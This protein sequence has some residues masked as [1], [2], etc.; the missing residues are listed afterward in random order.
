MGVIES[1]LSGD[2][3]NWAWLWKIVFTIITISCGFK[4]GEVVPSFFIGAT[5][6]CVVGP[7]LGVPAPFAAATGL[8]CV[9]CGAV[10]APL[11]SIILSIELF[12]AEGL[13][14][15]GMACAIS[16]LLSGYSGLYKSQ[17]IVYSKM[18][19]EF[20]NVNPW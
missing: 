6:G 12:G 7:L 5:F 15:F 18:R 10:N 11:A 2:A 9:F 19:A 20:I 3:R 4:G 14:Y 13:I 8:I 16:Y 1:A 17:R